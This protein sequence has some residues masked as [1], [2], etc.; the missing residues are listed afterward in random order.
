MAQLVLKIVSLFCGLGGPSIAPFIVPIVALIMICNIP[1]AF[2]AWTTL[3]VC[4]FTPIMMIGSKGTDGNNINV[5]N[6]SD[7]QTRNGGKAFG[8]AFLLYYLC[9]VPTLCFVMGKACEVNAAI[10]PF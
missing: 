10:N 8:F 5:L 3:L 4:C 7:G 2:S 9:M 1:S 6:S